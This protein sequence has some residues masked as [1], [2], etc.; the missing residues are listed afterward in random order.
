MF[1]GCTKMF[2]LLRRHALLH[3]TVYK[4]SMLKSS[5][6]LDFF[7]CSLFKEHQKPTGTRADL[8][9]LDSVGV[10][11]QLL[12]SLIGLDWTRLCWCARTL[13]VYV[14]VACMVKGKIFF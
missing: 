2:R 10:Q 1:I 13:N 8:I 6:D 3:I 14:L 5:I 7:D 4:T 9:V 12:Y 11:L